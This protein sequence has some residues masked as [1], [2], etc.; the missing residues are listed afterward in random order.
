MNAIFPYF[1]RIVSTATP[2]PADSPCRSNDLRRIYGAAPPMYT[3]G[4]IDSFTKARK[5]RAEQE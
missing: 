1:G 3:A 5:S 2:Q 4:S